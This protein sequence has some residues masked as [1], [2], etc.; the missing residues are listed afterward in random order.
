MRDNVIK[1][2]INWTRDFQLIFSND[3]TTACFIRDSKYNIMVIVQS[4]DKLKSIAYSSTGKRLYVGY[5]FVEQWIA[6]AC[7]TRNPAAMFRVAFCES[8]TRNNLLSL[9]TSNFVSVS[10]SHYFHEALAVC[11][12]FHPDEIF[13]DYLPNKLLH[14]CCSFWMFQYRF[15]LVFFTPIISIDKNQHSRIK[16]ANQTEKIVFPIKKFQTFMV[17]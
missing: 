8:R 14:T 9:R 6:N 11:L 2:K 4:H 15:P 5:F 3:L 1:A 13:A 17:Y 7:N 16:K 10:L 12:N